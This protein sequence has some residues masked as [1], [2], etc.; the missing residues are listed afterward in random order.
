MNDHALN[1]VSTP[2][3]P[4]SSATLQ[5]RVDRHLLFCSAAT[6]GATVALASGAQAA[7]IASPANI[8]VAVPVTTTGTPRVYFDFDTLTVRTGTTA[9]TGSDLSLLD[10][11]ST[12]ASGYF[13]YNRLFAIGTTTTTGSVLSA[14]TTN[15]VGNTANFAAGT[16]V[17]SA[18]P[19]HQYGALAQHFYSS[20]GAV[21][22]YG[23]FT[24]T[25]TSYLGFDFV[26]A[27]GVTD[28]GWMQV[29]F[30]AAN[31]AA[32]QSALTVVRYAY[33][34]TGAPIATGA[35]PE[36]NE[37]ALGCLAAGATGLAVWRRRRTEKAAQA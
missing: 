24:T 9:P 29:T 25:G 19:F 31:Y 26:N 15:Q 5:N 32:N 16:T 8:N 1:T 27:A 13:K 20:G 10:I 14:Q 30:N 33:D 36:P 18:S 6:V 23:N 2:V 11:L 7:I 21:Y 37:M 34:N 22:N 4:S 35:V 3:I 12:T 28:Y 17:N